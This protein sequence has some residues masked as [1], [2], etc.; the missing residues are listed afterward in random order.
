MKIFGIIIVIVANI[1]ILVINVRPIVIRLIE[2]LYKLPLNLLAH[3]HN[4]IDYSY[5]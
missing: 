1:G 5:G 2:C 4:L 3:V